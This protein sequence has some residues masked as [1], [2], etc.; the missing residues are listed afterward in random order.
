M[1][2]IIRA[3]LLRLVR[4]RTILLVLAGSSLFATIST[5]TVLSSAATTDV[6]SRREGATR[7]ALE[8][9][10]GGTEAF[11]IGASFLGFLV[12]VTF[13]ALLA[14]ELSGGTYR[15]L[16]LR[17][18]HR[19]QVIVGKLAGILLVAAGA[20]AVAELAT[21]ALSLLVAP[22]QDIA[23]SSWSSIDGISAGLRDYATV[24]GGV[25]GW[26]VFGTMLAVVF[27]SAPLA[28]GVGFA[29]AG[30]FENIV[31]DSWSTGYRVFPGQVLASLIRGGTVELGIGRAV[32]TALLYSGV[33][34]MVALVIVAR[35]D[36]TA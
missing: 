21:F 18:P 7:A 32:V 27:R 24:L 14:N 22:S 5:V 26:A 36:V 9:P 1:T 6:A 30:P 34:A 4:R 10:G 2:R 33:A 31:V 19:L 3:E 8:G 23:T 11:A 29:W 15:S 16:L 12:F 13:I 25:A 17:H 35:R 20:V 28:L